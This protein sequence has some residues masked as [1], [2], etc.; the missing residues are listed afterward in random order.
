MNI[1][2]WDQFVNSKPMKGSRCSV[3]VGAFDGIHV[4]HLSLFKRIL[5]KKEDERTVVFTFCQNPSSILKKEKFKGDICTLR[6]KLAIMENIGIDTVILIDFSTDFSKLSGRQFFSKIE[7]SLIPVRI[8]VGYDFKCGRDND[9]YAEDIAGMYGESGVI[10]EIVPKFKYDDYP[11][12]STMIRDC[13]KKGEIA[14]LQKVM[15]KGYSIDISDKS[16]TGFDGKYYFIERRNISQVVPD[17][18]VF[19]IPLFDNG[20]YRD[21]RVFIDE[22]LIKWAYI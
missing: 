20:K 16:L 7:S 3:T 2:G 13:I 6:Q 22:Q 15:Y 1:Y 5:E 10:V 21:A 12:K 17:R 14:K 9:T 19:M 4:G 8:V 11:V 18:G